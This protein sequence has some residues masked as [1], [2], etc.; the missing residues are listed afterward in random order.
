VLGELAARGALP[1]A[2]IVVSIYGQSPD[3]API[4]RAC[5]TYGVPVIEDAAQSLGATYRGRPVGSFGEFA[6]FS[7][8]GNKIITSSGGG[9]LVSRDGGAIERARYLATQAREAAPHYEHTTVGYNYR[10]S[11]VLAAL[12]RAQ[13]KTLGDRVAAR[14][15]NFELYA[16]RLDGIPGLHFMPEAAYGRPSRWLT[17]ITLDPAVADT[18]PE[19]IRRALEARN[20]ESRP[21][22]KPMHLQPAF[23]GCR[24]RG[25]AVSERLF[26][27]G[28]A[29][30]SG[31]D[32]R[33][34]D[35]DRIAAIVRETC[36]ERVL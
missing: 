1:R 23:E 15:R 32:L 5:R 9:M 4:L 14:R 17:C 31:S 10:M 21:L 22:W 8:N 16:E 24:V 27:T 12:G 30:P 33:E 6:A 19:A 2:A 36:L 35:I 13:L 26:R 18:T 11:N 34:A 3:Y 28:L 20:I 29:L 25:G 7:F